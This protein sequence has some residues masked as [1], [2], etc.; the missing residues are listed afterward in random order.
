MRCSGTARITVM[1]Q[2]GSSGVANNHV[3]NKI[4]D[5]RQKPCIVCIRE[6]MEVYDEFIF[7]TYTLLAL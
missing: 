5:L 7:R 1:I 4:Y 3:T 2:Y 6:I